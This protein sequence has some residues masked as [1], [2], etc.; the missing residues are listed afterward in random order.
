MFYMVNGVVFQ[1][2]FYCMYYEILNFR[3]TMES[4]RCICIKISA[5][6]LINPQIKE[7]IFK[8]LT[9]YV[10]GKIRNWWPKKHP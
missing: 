7:Y 6:I 3:E 8:Q 2:R 4:S 1:A 9:M 5:L 10:Q